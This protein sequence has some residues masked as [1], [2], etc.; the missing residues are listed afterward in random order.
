MTLNI[1]GY[2]QNSNNL[3]D[4]G[5]LGRENIIEIMDMLKG[6]AK[7]EGAEKVTI[8]YERSAGS[9]ASKAGNAFERTFN[10]TD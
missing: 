6:F 1:A 3:E 9:T 5:S 7:A 10:L 4:I 2:F 8:K